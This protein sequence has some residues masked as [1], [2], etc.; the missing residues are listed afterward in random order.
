VLSHFMGEFLNHL[1]SRFRGNDG[2]YK[3]ICHE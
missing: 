2:C 1:D 3:G